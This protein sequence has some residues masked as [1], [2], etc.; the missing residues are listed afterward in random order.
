VDN[1][2]EIRQFLASRRA[3]ITPDQVGLPAGGTRRRVPGLRREE[4]AVLAGVSTEWYTRLEKGH[5][6]GVSED[7]LEAVAGALRLDQAERIYLFDLARAAKPARAPQ[8]RRKA[9]VRPSVQWMLDSMTSSAA[10]VRNGHLDILAINSLGRALYS[11][12]FDDER[13]PVNIARFHFLSPRAHDFYPD[14]D[15]A[16]NTTVALLRAEAG[17]DPHD[18]DLRELVGELST[19]SHEFRTRWAAHNVRIH[20]T[21]NKQFHHPDVG[22]LDL[23]YHSLDLP[24]DDGWVLDL[25]TYT[26]APGS[27][28]EDALKLLASW[29]AA[30]HRAE[31]ADEPS[32]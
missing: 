23:V 13:R 26:A 3:K 24:T 17:R 20:H 2:S 14:W 21:G 7:V 28:S 16:A 30:S 19:V 32:R 5:I 10:F 29:S 22:K 27:P 15:G 6:S 1:R 8:R 4:V 11:P 9:T 18:K 31:Q 12:M 25:T